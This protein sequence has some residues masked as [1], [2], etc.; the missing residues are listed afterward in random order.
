[1]IPRKIKLIIGIVLIFVVWAWLYWLLCIPEP[2]RPVYREITP[3]E[4]HRIEKALGKYGDWPIEAE[5][6]GDRMWMLTKWG[7]IWI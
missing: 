4:K 2:V 5:R 6:D 7:K 3:Q 1:M